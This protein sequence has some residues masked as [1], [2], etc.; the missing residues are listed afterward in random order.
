MYVYVLKR[1]NEGIMSWKGADDKFAK[2]DDDDDESDDGGDNES[3]PLRLSA[4]L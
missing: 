4:A 3:R 1:K 2:D